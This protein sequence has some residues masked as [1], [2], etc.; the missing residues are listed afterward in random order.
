MR[1]VVVEEHE[2]HAVDWASP[3][4]VRSEQLQF[5]EAPT[6]DRYNEQISELFGQVRLM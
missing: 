1:S 5:Q 3:I 4:T 2:K 6:N